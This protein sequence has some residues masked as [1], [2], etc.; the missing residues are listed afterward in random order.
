MKIHVFQHV[1]FEGLGSIEN[2]L[3]AHDATISYSHFYQDATLPDLDQIDALIVLGGPM[4]VHDVHDYPWL[5]EEAVFIARAIAAQKPV[6]GI[7]LGAQL[8]AH[9]LG[10]RVY[11]NDVKEIG[12]FPISAIPHS[13]DAF[14]FAPT[15]TVFHWHGETFDLPPDAIH[16]AQSHACRNQA[17]QLGRHV[18]GLQFH[19]ETTAQS[20]D[21]II[22]HCNDELLEQPYIQSESV[23]R[24][25]PA[26]QYQAVN[27]VMAEV[28]GYLLEGKF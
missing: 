21:A 14:H 7:C 27:A 23:L 16:L 17:F 8:I 26:S 20:A 22:S 15:S 12:W 18:I 28:L 19:L 4:S 9:S 10:A 24:A 6:L 3:V 2:W 25:A 5:A 13:D 11:K 1:A